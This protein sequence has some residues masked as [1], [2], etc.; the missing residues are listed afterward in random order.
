MS[1][2]AQSFRDQLDRL[3]DERGWN[4]PRLAERSGYSRGYLWEVRAGRKP[5]SGTLL[6]DL[7]TAFETQ[8]TLAASWQEEDGGNVQRRQV[9]AGFA[10][11]PAL[12]KR[13][14]MGGLGTVLLHPGSAGQPLTWARLHEMRNAARNDFAAVRYSELAARLPRLIS[15]AVASRDQS[16]HDQR[17]PFHALLADAYILGNELAIKMHDTGFAGIMA[18]RAVQEAHASGD[19][20][21]VARAAWRASIVLRRSRHRGEASAVIIDGA[22]QLYRS[23]ALSDPRHA[24]QYARMLCCHAY[25]AAMDDSRDTAY[26]LL[27]QAREVIKEHGQRYFTFDD[28]RLYGISV[29]RAVGDY[30]QAIAFSQEVTAGALASDERR[31]RR[32]EDTAIAWWGRGRAAETFQALLAAERIS[33]QEVRERP[34]ARRLTLNLLSCGPG[35]TGLSGLRE[36]AVRSGVI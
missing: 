28:A 31:A 7:D 13:P 27:S 20:L 10:A 29:A 25:T 36:F 18:D 5:P 35:V 12:G 3:L 15:A 17:A 11:L 1:V 16:A 19:P 8:G 23:T 24:A 33:V 2:G 30:G 21:E 32:L 34:W 6:H 22:E 26:T 9:L 14:L 4:L